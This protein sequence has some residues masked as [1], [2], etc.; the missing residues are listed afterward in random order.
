MGYEYTLQIAGIAAAL[1]CLGLCGLFIASSL[2]DR[3]SR[4]DEAAA[5]MQREAE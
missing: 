5:R 4:R 3:N 1:S 2:Y